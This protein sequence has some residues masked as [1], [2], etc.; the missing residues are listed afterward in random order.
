MPVLG[1][2]WGLL[3]GGEGEAWSGAADFEVSEKYLELEVLNNP[4]LPL[5]RTVS[6]LG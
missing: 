6:S 3:V 2:E 4:Y 1:W 5:G